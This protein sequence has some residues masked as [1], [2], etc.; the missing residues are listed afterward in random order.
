MALIR[1]WRTKV[2]RGRAAEYERFARD[3]SLP[4]FR[5]QAGFLGVLFAG[6]GAD[7]I[8]VSFWQDHEALEALAHSPTYAAT[9]AEISRTSFLVG[10]SSSEVFPIHGGQWPTAPPD[11]A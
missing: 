3:S 6:D 7:R 5:Q 4:M 2:E 1:I 11:T 10:D 8:V 9:V